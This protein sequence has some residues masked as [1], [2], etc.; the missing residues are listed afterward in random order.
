MR[1]FLLAS[2]VG[3][4]SLAGVAHAAN[5]DVCGDICVP[6]A[7]T[8]DNVYNLTKQIY[9]KPGAT[10]TIE[11][12]TVVASVPTPNGAGGLAVTKGAQI[13][14]CGTESD[15]VIFT[16][17]ADVATWTPDAS[18]PTGGDPKTGV[19]R[20]SAL[21]WG[22][23]TIMGCGYISENATPGN[24]A[25]CNASNVAQMEGLVPSGPG[26]TSV[27]YGGGDDDDD[28]G[29]ISYLS[30]RYG[31]R[32]IGLAN[33]LNGLSLGGIGRGTDIDH[34]EIMNNVDDGIEIW[35]GAVNIKH[36]SIWN[37]GDDS[38]DVDQGWRGKAQFG[39]IVQGYSLDASQ[40]SGVGDNCFETDG[41][42]DSDW[43][44]QTA[45]TI[46]N[47]TVIGQ[48]LDGDGGTAWR[49]N[50]KVQYR[51]CIFMDLGER[52]VRFDNLDGDGANGYGFN[53]T[54]SW[55]DHWTTQA[56]YREPV[57][58]CS[59]PEEIYGCQ[60][61]DGNLNEIKDSVFFRNLAP[62]AYTEAKCVGVFD[63]NCLPLCDNVLIP[64]VAD[65]DGP[66]KAITRAPLVTRGGKDMLR[67]T[68]LDPR[69]NNEATT[70]ETAT[71]DNGFF[72]PT[73]YRG[74]FDPA[75][76]WLGSWT[77]SFAY[78]FT[79]N[80]QVRCFDM[81]VGGPN[82]AATLKLT[83]TPQGFVASIVDRQGC[84]RCV[85]EELRVTSPRSAEFDCGP[86]TV[87]I[88]L[89]GGVISFSAGPFQGTLCPQ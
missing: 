36:F 2:A 14:I 89:Q 46:L 45:A 70:C 28:S 85:C 62:D 9:V 16:S 77:S 50:A 37:I 51:K 1:K 87:S 4:F 61:Q 24:V 5:I 86:V 72:C 34:V 17:T 67:V 76:N 48:P 33:E 18:H 65:V 58:G 73:K 12:G 64:G 53:G 20:E 23:L 38:F 11:A 52:L 80:Y 21:E 66:V 56:T 29:K 41:A 88:S 26:D 78:G 31:G 59:N 35:G 10:L 47:C 71:P 13:F 39:L 30:I 43:Q 15:P 55:K 6:T 27:L 49:D 57:N 25:T 32:V 3:V 7:W 79:P 19:W 81:K 84:W 68:F 42:E 40:G 82:P 69:A 83:R 74:A 75:T 8:S 22:N 44:P 60:I 63:A 54:L